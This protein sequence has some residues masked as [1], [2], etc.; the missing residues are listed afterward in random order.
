MAVLVRDLGRE[1]QLDV[2]ARRSQ[3][4]GREQPGHVELCVE[5]VREDP[6]H[7]RLLVGAQRREAAFVR[8]QVER[9]GR[10]LVALPVRVQRAVRLRPLLE[11]L[12]LGCLGLIVEDE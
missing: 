5:A 7:S 11:R 1:Q 10:P 8:L 4:E 2:V 9:Q 6:H 12:A 3:Q